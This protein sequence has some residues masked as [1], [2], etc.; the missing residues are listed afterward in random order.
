MPVQRLQAALRQLR[1]TAKHP[2]LRG[3]ERAVEPAQH[4]QRQN[5]VL[6]LAAL[7][8]VADQIRDAPQETDDLVMVHRIDSVAVPAWVASR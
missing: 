7:E 1:L 6:I 3:R 8:A 4:G 5:D 2:L